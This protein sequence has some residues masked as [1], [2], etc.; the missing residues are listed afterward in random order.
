MSA[1]FDLLTLVFE[2]SSTNAFKRKST[3]NFLS[4][5]FVEYLQMC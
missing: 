5:F 4:I 1:K 2:S 3:E